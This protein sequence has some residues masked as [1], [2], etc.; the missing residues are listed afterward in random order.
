LAV[1]KSTARYAA[2]SEQQKLLQRQIHQQA[3]SIRHEQE[4]NHVRAQ[5]A[6]LAA[7]EARSYLV[8]PLAFDSFLKRTLAMVDRAIT[9][10]QIA[11]LESIVVVER[12]TEVSLWTI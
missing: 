4:L 10:S 7:L 8:N 5:R 2:S 12:V 9:N 11:D 3:A 6:K 1:I